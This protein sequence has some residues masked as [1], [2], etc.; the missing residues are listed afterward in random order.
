MYGFNCEHLGWF[1]RGVIWMHN[2]YGACAV[3]EAL[4]VMPHMESMKSMKSMKPMK[5]MR[6]MAPMKPMLSN[7]FG[8]IPCSL[9]LA[10]GK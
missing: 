8:R 5:S 6:S 2:G 4:T 10:A 1:E 3:R 7:S 9:F